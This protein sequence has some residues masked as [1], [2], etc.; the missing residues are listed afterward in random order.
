MD[1]TDATGHICID[2]SAYRLSRTTDMIHS[3]LRALY[4][5]WNR[6]R[7][8]RKTPLRSDIDPRDMDC[9]ARNL[10][11]LE[12]LGRGNIRY[13][14][15]GT[16]IVD[17]F[18][19]E[20]RGM[21][22]QSIMA[23]GS[24]ESFTALVAETLDEPGIGYARLRNA[25]DERGVWEVN[26]LPL[27]SDFGVIDRAIGCLHQ[28]SGIPVRATGAPLRFRIEHM[29][30]DVIGTDLPE[31]DLART[32]FPHHELPARIE[33]LAEPSHRFLSREDEGAAEPPRLT[34]IDGGGRDS[35]DGGPGNGRP[36]RPG[37]H[38]RLVKK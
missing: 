30:V 26:L 3:E 33:G 6:L 7:A 32:D 21:N 1:G 28:L 31:I 27:R 14:L 10:F 16:A 12:N 8:G 29:S 13:R 37:G 23:A 36:R 11:I 15:A 38:L 20:L 19:M 9:D 25:A 5:Y 24:R 34:A 35:S 18:G 22:A 4:S 17:S 2:L